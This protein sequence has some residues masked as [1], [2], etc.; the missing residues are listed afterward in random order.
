MTQTGLDPIA[1]CMPGYIKAYTPQNLYIH[2]S[3][4]SVGPETFLCFFG[5]F[6]KRYTYTTPTTQ[7]QTHSHTLKHK[8]QSSYTPKYTPTW[9]RGGSLPARR[10]KW[11]KLPASGPASTHHLWGGKGHKSRH[12]PNTHHTSTTHRHITHS[13]THK[14]T[15]KWPRGG[16]LPA[17][18][19]FE[20]WRKLYLP[21]GRP[22]PY[23]RG[24]ARDTKTHIPNTHHTN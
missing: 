21:R 4:Q 24:E 13:Y 8:H 3:A 7:T 22:Q 18:H 15:P 5:V 2:V 1:G 23:T 11:R 12:I 10:T 20:M 6:H 14:Y 19:I 17:R 16:S 9:P